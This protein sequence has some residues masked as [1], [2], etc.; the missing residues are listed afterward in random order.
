MTPGRG[1]GY[2]AAVRKTHSLP[3]ALTIAGSDSGGGAGL[4]ADLKT[5]ASLGVH[6]T[7][8]V[9]C[10][11]AQ[12]P[13]RVLGLQPVSLALVRQ[14]LEAL[15]AEL[16]PR[17]AKTGLL[18]SAEIIREVIPFFSNRTRVPIIIDPVMLATSGARLLQ[19]SGVDLLRDKLFPLAALITPNKHEAEVLLEMR[20]EDEEDLRVAARRIRSQF[21]CAALVKGGHLRGGDQAVD[22]FFDGRTELMLSARFIKGRR[23]H[24]TGCSYSAAIAGYCALGY[25][26]AE[27]VSLAKEYITQ[28]IAQASPLGR[29]SALNHFWSKGRVR[30]ARSL[31]DPR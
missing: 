16:P 3:V 14:Q 30:K 29:H 4:Q 10:V 20:I 31:S 19:H 22:I 17:A 6:G 18:F 25:Q 9:T 11:T 24:G 27:S 28:A 1:P 2:A 23:T 5:F 21:G 8:V 7:S 15:F 12:N 13:R 26:L